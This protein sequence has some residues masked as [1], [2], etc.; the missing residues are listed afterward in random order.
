M[1]FVISGQTPAKKNSRDLFKN[2]RTGKP[3]IKPNAAFDAWQAAAMYE[4]IKVPYIRGRVQLDYMF[5][6]VDNA[7][8]DL[9]NMIASINDC[10]QAAKADMALQRGKVRAVKGT[11]IL[12]GDHWQLLRIGS[13]DAA[14][15]RENPRAVITVTEVPPVV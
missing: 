4:L 13:A 7:Q 11:G 14:I 8:R 9:D 15:D 1:Q 6:V 5:Y 12:A 10:L 3:I 2:P